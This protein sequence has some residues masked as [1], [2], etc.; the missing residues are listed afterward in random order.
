MN[1]ALQ[2]K[3]IFCVLLLAG[4]GY[5]QREWTRFRGPNGSGSISDASIPTSWTDQDYNWRID[6]P[7]IGHSSPVIWKKRIFVTS[8]DPESAQLS[9]FCFDVDDGG[10]LWRKDIQS[11]THGQHP[12]SSY[13][14]ATPA[15]DQ[16]GVIVSWTTPEAYHVIAT[17]LTGRERWR[18]DLGP[19]VGANGSGV[20]PIIVDDLVLIPNDQDDVQLLTR[21]M[22]N[23]N[24]DAPIGKSSVIALDRGSGD[25]RWQLP[26]KTTLASYATPCIR[27]TQNGSKELILIT[28]A[29]GVSGVDVTTG[30]INWEVPGVFSA[31]CVASP[32][33][34]KDLVIGTDGE[35]VNG[36]LLVAVKAGI[37]GTPDART[38]A[39]E[40]KRAVPLVPTPLYH[41]GLLFLWADNGIAS[42]VDGKTG[43]VHWRER[44]GGN[45]YSSPIGVG[46]HVL[47][48]ARNGEVVMLAASTKFQLISRMPLEQTTFA[49]PAVSDGVLYLRSESRLHSLGGRGQ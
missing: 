42:C 45:F 14:D 6:L 39:Y 22:G 3:V 30:K 40:V 23:E 19:F 26:R 9:I 28:E 20:S 27:E 8:A 49:T 18:R 16:D 38:L 7:G 46:Q 1:R 48:V 31:R 21:L 44:V 35:G 34:V 12:S 43:Q 36:S 11:K 32:I 29:Q 47:C 41:N 15:V 10:Q 13:A 24:P 17:D 25:I 37:S 5:G 33:L 4:T 2:Y